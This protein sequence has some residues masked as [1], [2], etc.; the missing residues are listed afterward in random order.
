MRIT[1]EINLSQIQDKQMPEET[2]LFDKLIDHLYDFTIDQA[3]VVDTVHITQL[4][5]VATSED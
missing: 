2:R 1:I 4:N 3:A 5:G